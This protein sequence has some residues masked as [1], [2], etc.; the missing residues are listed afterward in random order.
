MN[1]TREVSPSA[2]LAMIKKG[3]LLVDV[4][5]PSEIERKAFDVP[6]I[7]SIPL[8]EIEKRYKEIP[9]NRQV[10]LACRSG[11]RSLM[12]LQVL[13]SKGHRKAVSMQSGISGWSRAELPIRQKQTQHSFSWLL[14]L[15]HKK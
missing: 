3:A 9:A 8:R 1:K 4:R 10:I 12:A 6:D 11:N 13:M 2:A 7:M 5:E 15:F 14:R